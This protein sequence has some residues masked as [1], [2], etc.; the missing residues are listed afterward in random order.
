MNDQEWTPITASDEIL[1]L[2]VEFFRT[3]SEIS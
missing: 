2:P 1:S 3:M